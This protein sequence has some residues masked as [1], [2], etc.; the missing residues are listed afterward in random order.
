ME[1]LLW[2]SERLIAG[3]NFF[4]NKIKELLGGRLFGGVLQGDK[5]NIMIL[6]PI[7]QGDANQVPGESDIP[8]L[9]GNNGNAVVLTNHVENDIVPVQSHF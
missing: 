6:D 2:S 5:S 4:P 9:G 3:R 1:G 8:Q 7:Q